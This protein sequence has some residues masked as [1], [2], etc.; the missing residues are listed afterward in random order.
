MAA[1]TLQSEL[2]GE[3][4]DRFLVNAYPDKSRSYIQKCIVDGCIRVNGKMVLKANC[5][6]H[7]GESVEVDFPPP[8]P[9]EV[10]AED[11]PLDI[12]YED[13]DVI[14]VNKARGMVV[15][16]AAGAYR[17]TLV[18]ALLYHTKDLSGIN[19]VLRP[20]I[21]HRLDKD[22]S[23]VMIVAKNDAA[24]HVLA[25]E[26][27]TKTAKRK[28]LAIVCGNI[29]AEKGTIHGA[30]GRSPTDRKKMAVVKE[31]G[32]PATTHFEVLKRFREHCLVRCELTTGRTHQIRVHLAHIGHPL[33]NDPAYGKIDKRLSMKG[34]ALHSSELD[35]LHPRTK[36][37]MH[38]EAPMPRDMEEALR[39]LES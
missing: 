25:E 28:Y 26:I 38:F 6:L 31:N 23:G 17:G 18:N 8:E 34:Q 20:G 10:A 1:D 5:R 32:K 16:P 37:S 36:E 22:T 29:P 14:V 2:E 35:F 21:V 15:H 11:I 33:L 13:S 39:L 3:R 27:A 9:L 12:L 19:G 4:L 7:A 30:I 24:H